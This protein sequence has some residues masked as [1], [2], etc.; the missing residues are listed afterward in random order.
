MASIKKA[1]FPVA[2]LG[3]RFLPA[4]KATPKEMLPVVDKPLIQ[5]AVEEAIAAGFTEMLFVTNQNKRPIEDHF[6]SNYELESKLAEQQKVELLDIVHSI[7][8]SH[9]A[10]AYIRQAQPL[11]LGHAVLCAE[12]F[13][14]NEP[15]AVILADDLIDSRR[16]NCLQKMREL[17]EEKAC[18]ILAVETILAEKST[19]YGVIKTSPFDPDQKVFPVED[20]VEKPA[21]DVAPSNL[22]VVGRYLLTP[23]IFKYL[24]QGKRGAGGEYQLTDAL[25]AL[26]KEEPIEA[27]CLEEQRFDCGSKLGYLEATVAFAL[28]H[29]E[30]RNDFA[31][32]LKNWEQYY[33]N[34]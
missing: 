7:L 26:L 6:D 22:G 17:F 28:R 16:Y 33:Q 19:Q 18:S 4:T 3:T 9:I 23:T 29:P 30:L 32:C 14:N 20:I 31:K 13:V 34:T 5:Y 2:G 10:C 27:L 12:P 24:K 11:G 25:A 1:V 15:F 21:P 8:P